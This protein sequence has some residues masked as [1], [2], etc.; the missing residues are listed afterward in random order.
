MNPEEIVFVVDDD[1]AVRGSLRALLE[2]V[3]FRVEDFS[4]ADAFL[5]ACDPPR[6]GCLVV[7]V[8]MPGMDGIELQEEL[9]RR[10]I[11][12]P[13]IVITGH[14]DVPLAV[15]AMKAG[16]IDFIEK[17]FDDRVLIDSIRDALS[18]LRNLKS[19]TNFSHAATE[20]VDG[21]TKRERQ[22]LEHLVAGRPNK[23][24][25]HDLGISPRTVEVHRAN[26]MEKLQTRSLSGLVR[27]ALEAG[28]PSV[29]ET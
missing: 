4:S 23:I 6:P 25:A 27:I 22:V 13:V 3:E 19:R 15:R 5:D 18:F 24:I 20:R 7:D 9:A 10:H 11:E 28:V 17:P 21:L 16:A 2:A 1:A 26:L 8:R 29:D 12:L 14:G